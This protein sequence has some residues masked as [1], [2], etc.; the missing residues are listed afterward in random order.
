MPASKQRTRVLIT[1]MTYPHP[2]EKYTEL[3]CTAGITEAGEWVRLYPI[4]YRYR[5]P[6]QRFRKYQWIEVDL[7]PRGAGNDKRAESRRPNLDTIRLIGAPISSDRNWI[8]RRA[9]IDKLPVF[10]RNQLFDLHEADKA[11]GRPPVSLGVVR[12]TK[13]V[14]VLIEPVSGDWKPEWK[15]MLAQGNLFGEELKEIRKL[16]FAWKYVFECEDSEGKPHTAMNEDWEIG[17]LYWKELE[18]LGIPE[19]AAESVR[20]KCLQMA[21]PDR[22]TKFFMG[23]VF[24][25]NTWI[26]LG[27][28]WPKKEEQGRLGAW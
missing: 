20:K 11:A 7:G 27:V 8:Q 10:T 24:P 6:E 13:V 4:D 12:P 21:A 25:Y 14:D 5:P 22:D 17:V 26:V 2:S 16:P 23:T 19:L 18:R 1:V 3:V 28:F 15:A 9:I